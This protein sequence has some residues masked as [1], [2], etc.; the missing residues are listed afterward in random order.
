MRRNT[1]T[2]RQ[3]AARSVLDMRNAIRKVVVSLTGGSDWNVLGYEFEDLET[4]E[5]TCEGEGDPGIP[6]F[7]GISIFARPVSANGEA[8]LLHVGCEADHP[9]IAAV[10]DEDGRRAYV[11]T[12]GEVAAGE[13]A[14]YNGQGTARV[15]VKAD[16]T[17][18]INGAGSAVSLAKLAELALLQSTIAGVTAVPNDG[19]QAIITA[20]GALSSPSGTSVLKAE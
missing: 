3:R 6:V 9:V 11:D 17:V 5:T 4:G 8:V 19:G 18:E 7:Q 16:G 14:I 13:I 15:I 20:V 12:F 10:R 1:K 2:F